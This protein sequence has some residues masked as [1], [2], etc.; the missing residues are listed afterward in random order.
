MIPGKA[1]TRILYAYTENDKLK[2]H[3][4]IRVN[5]EMRDGL[6]MLLTF[7]QHPSIF[8]RAFLDYSKFIIANE[9]DMYSDANGRIGVGAI[10]GSSWMSQK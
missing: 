4:Y 1:I 6:K 5:A 2:P 7:I 10:C 9:I 8:C 3:F